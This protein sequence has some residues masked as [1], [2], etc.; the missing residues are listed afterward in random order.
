MTAIAAERCL[1]YRV[2]WLEMRARPETVPVPA[3]PGEAVSLTEAEGFPRWYFFALYDA[4]GQDYVWEDMHLAPRG[5]VRRFLNDGRTRMYTM[6]RQGWPQGF[7][8]LD[9]R[10][11]GICDISYFGLVGR[12]SARGSAA[13]CSTARCRSDGNLK[14]CGK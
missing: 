13:G 8:L 12:R 14:E 9:T 10:E 1:S 3:P 11:P 5:E 4:V 2:D 7:F 6:T